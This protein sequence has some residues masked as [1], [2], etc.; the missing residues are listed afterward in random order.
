MG[1]GFTSFE[2]CL[3]LADYQK[4]CS[5]NEYLDLNLDIRLGK[6]KISIPVKQFYDKCKIS[7]LYSYK[8]L[9]DILEKHSQ[10]YPS[11]SQST[12]QEQNSI[13]FQIQVGVDLLI[14]LPVKQTAQFLLL[15]AGNSVIPQ[16]AEDF[17]RLKE[18]LVE[19]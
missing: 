7:S 18:V 4:F 14:D 17:S 8:W 3:D 13:Y 9:I 2:D 12:Y 16:K 19:S 15:K 5:P 10:F 11:I 6:S 1:I